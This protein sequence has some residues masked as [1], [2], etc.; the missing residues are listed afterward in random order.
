M[1]DNIDILGAFMEDLNK[2]A[3]AASGE[4]R[5]FYNVVPAMLQPGRIAKTTGERPEFFPI[6]AGPGSKS[7][8]EARDDAMAF[9]KNQGEEVRPQG[10]RYGKGTYPNLFTGVRVQYYMEGN[11]SGV[12]NA[13]EL[14]WND[15]HFFMFQ[16]RR[17]NPETGETEWGAWNKKMIMSMWTNTDY[18]GPVFD[19]SDYGKV[20]YAVVKNENDRTFDWENPE[21]NDK[22][23]SK[24]SVDE[25][26]G[27][28]TLYPR[29]IRIITEIC[30]DLEMAKARAAELGVEINNDNLGLPDADAVS[31]ESSIPA[32]DGYNAAEV[33]AE[34]PDMRDYLVGELTKVTDSPPPIRNKRVAA[35]KEE[36]KGL[37]DIDLVS[38]ILEHLGE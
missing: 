18:G 27:E 1:T 25:E 4:S 22:Y 13:E 8:D 11:F 32:P 5:G 33:G 12:P 15:I 7:P 31:T 38:Y 37:S 36:T 10:K 28:T 26:T 20:V 29:R 35:L 24:E 21:N 14:V 34:W 17:T 23:N 19:L 2:A 30:H 9:I 16:E 3:E 6:I